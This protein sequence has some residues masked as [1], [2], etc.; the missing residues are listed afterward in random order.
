ML[1]IAG[2]SGEP[3][4]AAVPEPPDDP[5]S[6]REIG[7]DEFLT[8]IQHRDSRCEF[9]PSGVASSIFAI[10]PNTARGDMPGVL[11][12]E[13]RMTLD[14]T[15]PVPVKMLAVAAQLRMHASTLSIV[16]EERRA[17]SPIR[18]LCLRGSPA[19]ILDA[20]GRVMAVASV[21]T[22]GFDHSGLTTIDIAPGGMILRVPGT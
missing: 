6:A 14:P 21:I 4:S 11:G 20:D 2:C 5:Q 9:D 13:L 19:R 17:L 8:M 3:R 22:L 16:F 15:V 18:T 7:A 1:L 12:R 10:E